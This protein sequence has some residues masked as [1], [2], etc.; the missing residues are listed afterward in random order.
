M[1]VSINKALWFALRNDKIS[2]D[3]KAPI[4][5]FYSLNGVRIK[6]STGFKMYPEYW[7]SKEN[8]ANWTN[9]LDF[10]RKYPLFPK[11]DYLD[12]SEIQALNDK[13]SVIRGDVSEI[14]NFFKVHKTAFSPSMVIEELKIKKAKKI[15][16]L[17]KIEEPNNYLFDFMDQYIRD[18]EITRAKGSLS[19]YKSVKKHLAAYQTETRHKVTF[20]NIDSK[21]FNKFNAFLIERTKTDLSGVTSPMLNN[22][23]IA[24]SLSTLKTF[25]GYARKHGIKVTDSYKDYSIKK[26]KL[27]VIALE[28][29]ELDALINIDLSNNKRLDRVRDIFVFSASSGMRYSDTAMLKREHIISN[30][31]EFVVKKTKQKLSIPLNS[32]SAAILRKYKND[33]KILP[34]V[35]NQELNRCLKDLCKLAGIDTPIE[36][37]RYYGA[38]RVET[39][40]QKWELVHFHTA[41]KTFASL[42]LEKGM[43]AEEVM[44]A[45]GWETYNS[46]KRYVK[47]TKKALKLSVVKAWGEVDNLKIVG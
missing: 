44:L 45:G 40:Y 33:R 4:I 47:I 13:L 19:V 20:E 16:A 18:H 24:K 10:G 8:K 25:L 26:Q 21:F 39:I 12:E 43:S 27:E 23:T 9:R 36:I 34:M 30:E 2:A 35:T 7:N 38:K 42:S 41:R 32:I 3:G 46:F 5:M 22:T 15:N 11:A 1:D 28:Q 14:E 29:S 31:I 6:Y 37:V 17:L